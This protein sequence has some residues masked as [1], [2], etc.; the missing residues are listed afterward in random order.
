M[1]RS[2][3]RWLAMAGE[4]LDTVLARFGTGT[5]GFYDTAD[6]SER[7]IYR[8]SDVADGPSP[9]GTFA[10]A[11]ALLSYA[12]LTGLATYREAAIGALASIP[13]LASRFP[14][15]AGSG[16]AVA[17]ALLSGPAEIAIVGPAGP[18]RTELHRVAAQAAPPGAVIAV[19]DGGSSA[20]PLM[21]GRTP[22]NG[23]AAAYVCRDFSCRAPV[24]EPDQLREA[25]K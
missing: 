7:L 24:T 4:L 8:P 22:V 14:R 13:A 6:D 17:E 10:V 1:R 3:G 20:I 25:L 5:G 18:E 11:D 12:A 2:A 16:L 9:S 21:A 23:R 19:G 15:A